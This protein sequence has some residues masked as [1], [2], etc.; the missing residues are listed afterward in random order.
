ML[1]LKRNL[2]Q[3]NDECINIQTES[4]IQAAALLLKNVTS[5]KRR[6]RAQHQLVP[7]HVPTDAPTCPNIFQQCPQTSLNLVPNVYPCVPNLSLTIPLNIGLFLRNILA[8]CKRLET[9]ILS[10]K[11]SPR[12]IPNIIP[13]CSHFWW[14][15]LDCINIFRNQSC[16]P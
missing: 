2:P 14:V 10:H 12:R 16:N 1:L 9:L 4:D 13:H 6:G 8:S 11:N 3:N 15:H 7:P 5:D